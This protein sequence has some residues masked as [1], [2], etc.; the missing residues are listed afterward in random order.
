MSE[1]VVIAFGPEHGPLIR[2]LLGEGARNIE[3]CVY[4]TP[5]YSVYKRRDGSIVHITERVSS[6]LV[7]E[8]T[9]YWSWKSS[10]DA[11][12][13]TYPDPETGRVR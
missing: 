6:S 10:N 9:D 7:Y 8:F 11:T 13:A 4:V 2:A 3:N 5:R 12:W 1:P